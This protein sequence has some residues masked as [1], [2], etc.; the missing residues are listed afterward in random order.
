MLYNRFVPILGSWT[1]VRERDA[2]F[3][4]WAPITIVD[5]MTIVQVAI[6]NR[7]VTVYSYSMGRKEKILKKARNNPHGLK[8]KEFEMLL[9]QCDWVFDHQRGSHHIWYSPAFHPL[10]IQPKGNMAKAYQVKQFLK[11][12]DEEFDEQI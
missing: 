11:R 7:S 3:Q 12:L 2:S 10:P 5:S 1:I 4:A 6:D 9:R 8:F